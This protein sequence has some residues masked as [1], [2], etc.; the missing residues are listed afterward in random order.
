MPLVL[1]FRAVRPTVTGEG[2]TSRLSPPYDVIARDERS[3]LAR[4]SRNPVHVILPEDPG[5]PGSRYD[6]AARIFRAWLGDGTLARDA[7][8][9]FY[10]YEQRF[11]HAG[12]DAR[13][14]GLFG[15]L[16]LRRFDE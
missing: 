9:A 6:E 13:R 16:E 1:P 15:L 10:P 3:R 11:A 4:E 2:L 12:K 7:R 5:G 8:A 14:V